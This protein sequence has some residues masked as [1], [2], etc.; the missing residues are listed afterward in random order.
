MLPN[1]NESCCNNCMAPAGN[2]ETPSSGRTDRADAHA[3]RTRLLDGDL[4][5]L[6]AVAGTRMLD[7][8]AVSAAA[9]EYETEEP[10]YPVESERLTTLPDAF[11]DGSFLWKDAEW[12]VRWY[13]R[14]SLG[15]FPTAE[16]E[17]IE[18][19]FRGNDR[20]DVQAVVEDVLAAP[21][22]AA[23]IDRLVALDG[24][25]RRVATAFLQFTDPETYLAVD[26]DSW[27]VLREADRLSA[28]Y[29]DALPVANYRSY[30]AAC[31]ALADDCDV[32]LVTVY[33]AL[34]RLGHDQ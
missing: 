30:L 5:L 4:L 12:V 18:G 2:R 27:G 32:D 25:D 16:R 10:L 8:A 7:C 14:R 31:R 3:V 1:N 17:A 33:R 6:W 15:A 11:R 22:V 23:K 29:P 34:W 20:E 9:R 26:A 28:P 24:V 13:C 19:A 21:D